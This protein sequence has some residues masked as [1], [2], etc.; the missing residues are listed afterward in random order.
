MKHIYFICLFLCLTVIFAARPAQ[1]QTETVLY[2]FC[3]QPSCT[4]GATPQSSLTF[5][6]GGNLYGTTNGGGTF[7]YGTVFELSPN[8]SGGWNETVLYS[9]TGGADGANPDYSP[10]IFDSVGN[11]YGTAYGGG[12]NGY[13]VVWE[14]SPVGRS[15]TETV[16]YSFANDGDGA[17]P[18]AGV[19]MDPAGNLYGTTTPNSY[20]CS[21]PG[22]VFELSPSGG[23]WAEQ[24]I[25]SV[26]T[27]TAGL[28][29]D[30][31]G[32]IFG[33][34]SSIVFELS[35][36]GNGGWSP[37]VIHTFAS[38]YHAQGTP[39]LDKAGKLY[40]TASPRKRSTNGMVYKLSPGKKGT[41]AYKILYSFEGWQSGDGYDPVGGVV[42]DM[43]GNVYGTTFSGGYPDEQAG[44]VFE[45]VAPVGKGSYAEK[46]LLAFNYTD[47]AY[48]LAGP[49]LDSAGNLYGT[50]EYGGSSGVY[51]VVFEVTP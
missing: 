27:C 18:Q 13:G 9:F 35:P 26:V 1:A 19:I 32:N 3:S 25:Y 51:G 34:G 45:L 14:L 5:D 10:V 42:L 37:T 38:R 24:A 16:L 2:N 39:V 48:P 8:G 6:A 47:G 4:D 50:T 33:V 20:D 31:A 22:T 17:Y 43:A 12:A 23:G 44:I 36:N 7:G 49:I 41:W 46:V 21:E 11:L 30:A 29:M 40:G 15:W 28:A